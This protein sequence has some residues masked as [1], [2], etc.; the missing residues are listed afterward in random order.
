ML[1]PKG[2]Q[3]SSTI[4]DAR[5]S[6]PGQ[7]ISWRGERFGS[8]WPIGH[9]QVRAAT[10]PVWTVDLRVGDSPFPSSYSSFFCGRRSSGETGR[11]MAD[12]QE[13]GNR[14]GAKIRPLPHG[15]A[16]LTSPLVGVKLPETDIPVLLSGAWASQAERVARDRRRPSVPDPGNA[17]VGKT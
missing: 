7:S 15:Q 17:G 13:S 11:R 10:A 12:R 2:L 9:I 3:P 8:F 16:A 14:T 6:K 5:K 4:K 1:D